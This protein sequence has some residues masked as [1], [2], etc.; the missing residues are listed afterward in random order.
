LEMI[1]R[2]GPGGHFLNEDHTL[3][4]FRDVWYSNVFDRT[5]YTAWLAEDGRRFEQRLR[6]HTAELMQHRPAPLPDATLAELE[7]MARHWK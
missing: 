5:I 7:K 4:H 1:D 6:D 2:V 3:R